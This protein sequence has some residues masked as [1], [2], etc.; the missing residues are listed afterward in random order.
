M[1]PASKF[2]TRSFIIG[3]VLF[4]VLCINQSAKAQDISEKDVPPDVQ[5]AFAKKYMEH[6][7]AYWMIKDGFYIVSFKTGKEY[8][9]ACYSAKG[10]WIYTERIIDFTA[11]P[12]AVAD[13]LHTSQF[14]HWDVGNTYTVEVP[15]KSTRYRLFVYSATWDELELNF[16]ANGTLIL[17]IP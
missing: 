10:K 2:L 7:E 4:S 5:K 13:S 17:D 9:D 3:F 15:G 11:L 14:G 6:S 12:K 8:L 16:E 1:Q